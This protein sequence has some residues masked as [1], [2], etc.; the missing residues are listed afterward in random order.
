MR[1][2]ATVLWRTTRLVASSTRASGVSSPRH[3]P[4]RRRRHLGQRLADGGQRRPRPARHRQVVE[5]DDAEVVGHAQPEHAR[6]LVD[7]EGLQVAAGEDRGRRVGQRQQRAPL[8]VGAL[9]VEVAVADQL[10][11][12]GQR[13]PSRAPRGSRPRGRGCTACP[14]GRRSCR[15][16]RWPSSSR[17]RVAVRP[18]FQLV[19]PTDG[20]SGVGLAGRVDDHER[21]RRGRCSRAPAP[22]ASSDDDED[23]AGGAARGD[24]V[25]PRAAQARRALA[26]RR[27]RRRGSCSRAT[28]STPRMISIAHGL[29]SSLKTTS[30]SAA[31]RSRDGGGGGSRA[32]AAGA[33]R[34]RGWRA[35]RRRAR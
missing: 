9:D 30:S 28:S 32:R 20:T 33:R 10:R 13:R 15:S 18:P 8:L 26:A 16:R 7:A 14:A 19:A 24:R 5:A 35:R 4:R 2:R 1:S 22:R 25:D 29:S 12:D 31:R 11:V 17:W 3:D 27:A 34:A 21:D 6:G 23:H